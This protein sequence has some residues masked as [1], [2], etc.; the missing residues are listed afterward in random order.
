MLGFDEGMQIYMCET[1]V[2][3]FLKSPKRISANAISKVGGAILSP[4]AP[5]Y[6]LA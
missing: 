5:A 6:A 2:G 3:I 4:F 1:E